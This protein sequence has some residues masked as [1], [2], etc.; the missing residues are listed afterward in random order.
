MDPHFERLTAVLSGAVNTQ[1][2]TGEAFYK[3]DLLIHL[4]SSIL[5]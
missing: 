5:A 1:Q 2:V 4:E 3:V